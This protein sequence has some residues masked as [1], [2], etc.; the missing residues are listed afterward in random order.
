M[1]GA[2]LAFQIKFTQELKEAILEVA[3]E[4]GEEIEILDK[5]GNRRW[6]PGRSKTR[7]GIAT[8]SA[9]QE[10]PEDERKPAAL[11]KCTFLGI[12]RRSALLGAARSRLAVNDRRRHCPETT[13]Q[14]RFIEALVKVDPNFGDP[15]E[16]Y[17]DDPVK[18]KSLE[19]LRRADAEASRDKPPR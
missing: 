8:T 11:W 18:A 17:K 15:K 7:S 10:R 1:L 19:E 2:S 13:L 4:V 5:D 3:E 16:Q 12:A 14:R 9:R 6:S